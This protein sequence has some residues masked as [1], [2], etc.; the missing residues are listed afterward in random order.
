MSTEI[1]VDFKK[2]LPA[3]MKETRWGEWVEAYQ[4][5][6]SDFKQEKVDILIDRFNSDL[7]TSDQFKIIAA[8]FGWNLSSYDGW[9]NELEYFKRQ[10]LLIVDRILFKTTRRAYLDEFYI[11]N[12]YGDVYPLL[13]EDV[14][15]VPY[16]L[17][18]ESGENNEVI[19]IL[20]SGDDNI[21]YYQPYTFDG[22]F[23]FDG[24]NT[25]DT[26][27]PIYGNPRESGLVDGFLDTPAIMRM[28]D[29]EEFLSYLIRQFIIQFKYN[30]VENSSEF[31]STNTM[32]ALYND[33]QQ[34]KRL[35][36]KEYYEPRLNIRYTDS[37]LTS[38][39][40]DDFDR[41]EDIAQ[42]QTICDSGSLFNELFEVQFGDGAHSTFD[43]LTIS[44]VSSYLSTVTS[45]NL[46]TEQTDDTWYVRKK[47]Y[48]NDTFEDFTEIA[49]LYSGQCFLYST[50][51]AVR[52]PT[53]ARA[54]ISFDFVDINYTP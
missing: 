35:T 14:D 47:L 22:L 29:E 5:L 1:K 46:I 43:L 20:D 21:L 38:T 32:L 48:E 53:G 40:Y 45:G 54:N 11:Y 44:G 26:V 16:E 6:L 41:N 28:L 36:E 3:S 13:Q 19:D 9:A 31:L 37:G 39:S 15:L 4:D 27:Y 10:F 2:L 34:I 30:L 51:P 33:V 50:F 25:F 17:W 52:Y 12:L 18:H 8:K 24:P 7:M 49:L 23:E 42:M